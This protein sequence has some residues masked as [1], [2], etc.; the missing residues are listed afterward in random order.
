MVELRGPHLHRPTPP[1]AEEGQQG[2]GR[3]FGDRRSYSIVRGEAARRF[4]ACATI[5]VDTAAPTPPAK[6]IYVVQIP[7]RDD[8]CCNLIIVLCNLSWH[9]APIPTN[10]SP[11]LPICAVESRKSAVSLVPHENTTLVPMSGPPPSLSRLIVAPASN[12]SV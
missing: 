12:V 8:H 3:G 5:S 4:A 1:P 10:R 11:S 6:K 2:E 9:L 7:A